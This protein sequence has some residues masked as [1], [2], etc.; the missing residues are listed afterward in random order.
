MKYEAQFFSVVPMSDVQ[1]I[2]SASPESTAKRM[3]L[4][5]IVVLIF[6]SLLFAATFAASIFNNDLSK[7]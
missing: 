6:G 2:V 3:A 1:L 5:I 4:N 7:Y